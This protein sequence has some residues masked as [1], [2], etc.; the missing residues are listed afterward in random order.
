MISGT[1]FEIPPSKLEVAISVLRRDLQQAREELRFMRE[2]VNFLARRIAEFPQLPRP[3]WMRY[4][5]EPK[6]TRV[7]IAIGGQQLVTTYDHTGREI[8]WL[9]G[10]FQEIG[11]RVLARSG[12]LPWEQIESISP[13]PDPVTPVP[14]THLE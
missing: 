9:C 10:P 4:P 8:P 5:V 3:R 12:D 7:T 1:I 13:T 2:E 11:L 14:E 6:I